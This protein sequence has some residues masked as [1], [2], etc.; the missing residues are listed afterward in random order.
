MSSSAAPVADEATSE[1]LPEA[2]E[3]PPSPPA[4]D[5]LVRRDPGAEPERLLPPIRYRGRR[6]EVPDICRVAWLDMYERKV[7]PPNDG[8]GPRDQARLILAAKTGSLETLQLLLDQGTEVVDAR[9]GLNRTALMYAAQGGRTEHALALMR[10]GADART[11]GLWDARGGSLSALD[12][13]LLGGHR[14]TAER[15]QREVLQN[16]LSLEGP[17]LAALDEAG[18]TPL[19]WLARNA[20]P[21]VARV[22]LERGAD[23]EAQSC[24]A[25]PG[26]EKGPQED[27]P[28]SATPLLLAAWAENPEVARLLLEFKANARAVDERGRG[29]FHLMRHATSLSLT[30]DLLRAG[31]DPMLP[32]REGKTALDLLAKSGLRAELLQALA[33][34]NHPVAGPPATLEDLFGVLRRLAQER[35]GA[36]PSPAPVLALLE[37][38]ALLLGE[39]DARGRTALFEAGAQ[40]LCQIA[41]TLVGRGARL[42]ARDRAGRSPLHGARDA[43]TVRLFVRLGADIDARDT[44][45]RTPLLLR[46]STPGSLAAVSALLQAGAN[47]HLVDRG[48]QSAL[49]LARAS[50]S[51]DVVAYLETQL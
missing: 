43:D 21:N 2:S 9:D 45:G 12:A 44:D 4:A 18:E 50:G 17:D 3:L 20:G 51:A 24:P 36:D 30:P 23:L 26:D 40:G 33:A 14:E 29:V 35:R 19:H 16:F 11:R 8:A 46:A 28:H 7:A 38:D 25:R 22:L 48:Q 42:D 31:A 49:Q 27:A 41:E 15:I 10:A 39:T 1:P 32:D 6:G 5:T 13:A 37:R 34:A 47:A